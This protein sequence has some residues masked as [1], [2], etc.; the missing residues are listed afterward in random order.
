VWHDDCPNPPGLTTDGCVVQSRVERLTVTGN[1]VTARKVLVQDWCQQFSSHSMG[2][3][4]FGPD[5]A[6][7]VGGGEGANFDN[8]DYGEF[9]GTQAG[10][11]TPYNPCGDPAVPA[12]ARPTPPNAEGGALRAQDARTP[13]DPQTLDGT[14]IRID[15]DTGAALPDNPN[16]GAS[17]A[18]LRRIIG[19]GF[20]N[21]W[22]LSF[23]PGTND[24]YEGDVGWNQYEE[25]NN[26]GD[27][28]SA[29][30][31][32]GWPCYEGSVPQPLF[33]P[34]GLT[35]CNNLYSSGAAT[36]PY[37]AY[38][39]SGAVKT[40]D[41]CGTS[42]GAITAMTFY[43]NGNY[44]AQYH[45]AL[46]FGDYVRNCL[47]VMT[48]GANGKP[49]P[50]TLTRFALTPGTQGHGIV[51]IE[52]GPGGD[53]YYVDMFAG[54]LN[55]IR[56]TAGGNTPPNAVATATPN[57]GPVPLHVAFDGRQ[58]NDPDGDAI[59]YAWDLDGDGAYD[60]STSATPTRDYAQSGAVTVGLKVTDSRGGSDTTTVVVTPGNSPPTITL[61]QPTTATT[62]H[63][64][65]S[66]P[67][68]A[69]ATDLDDGTIPASSFSW[70]VELHHCSLA[71][72]CHLHPWQTINDVRSGSFTAP[73]HGYPAYLTVT[74]T[75]TDS[76][77]ASASKSVDIQPETTTLTLRSLPSGLTLTSSNQSSAS[78]FTETVIVGS[79]NVLTA[80]GQVM[81]GVGYGFDGWSDG[82]AQTH[83]RNV[84]TPT[85]LTASFSPRTLSATDTTVLERSTT[86]SLHVPVT[87]NKPNVE[88][89][90]VHWATA[91]GT[92]TAPGDFTAS[93]G[94]LTFPPGSTSEDAI[95]PIAGDSAAEP[96]QTFTVGLSG[97][98]KASIAD[99][100]ATVT[101]YDDDGG[102][103]VL[104]PGLAT[105][106]EGA[107]GTSVVRIPY[108]LSRPTS[109][110]VTAAWS[111]ADNTAAA[112]S[113]YVTSSGTLRIIAGQTRT[114]VD[115]TVRGDTVD[116][117]DEMLL[118]KLSGLLNAQLGG[119]YGVG[120]GQIVDDD[121]PPGSPQL[122]GAVGSVLEGDSA[123][124]NVSIPITLSAPSTHAV[125]AS[126]T[127]QDNWAATAPSDYTSQSGSVRFDPGET[128]K[129][130]T[131]PVVGDTS[132]ETDETLL[133]SIT[134]VVG[135][136]LGGWG[137]AF[138][139][140]VDD[141]GPPGSPDL[142]PGT[143]SA[144]EGNSGTRTVTVPVTLSAATS[145]TVTA[146]WK[147]ADFGA[148]APN[149]Y[150]AASGTVT[151]APGSTTANVVVTIVGD[152]VD[153][154]N[155]G[156]VLQFTNVANAGL[157]SPTAG[158]VTILDDDP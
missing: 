20:R 120:F 56:Y 100:S 105:V 110:D 70:K 12:G 38:K 60:D 55:R 155:E 91:P 34:I 8:P 85:T 71:G 131:V 48:P 49:D 146:S 137:Y 57:A 36:A 72:L 144:T 116:E 133:V 32:Y 6:L 102:P 125:T 7:Y 74:V 45:G 108:T 118:V 39:Q 17:D 96:T 117:P 58:S 89:V 150:L 2:G 113:D 50:A 140:I 43:G 68:S 59:T 115:V 87:L 112:G 142:V 66:V 82:G 119:F 80:A 128:T 156:F 33:Q 147:T 143:A 11:P 158:S 104:T 19:Y 9:G 154:P 78:P 25:V 127:T 1:V 81:N 18:N 126:W 13:G 94:T 53:L 97:A 29:V 51:N 99:A 42:G 151:I 61:T 24:L 63:V 28:T 98:T 103:P 114:S 88:P 86:Q 153:E 47:W 4:T 124:R 135:A 52:P 152:T 130:V 123:T 90:T 3:M 10:T 95:V 21:P 27:P 84:S 139:A 111:T 30:E 46:F 109:A 132:D 75:V 134:N 64:N 67:F 23:R 138:G 76:D 31:D 145:S 107:G 157:G 93:S 54:A 148:V 101:I 69:T 79:T 73:D 16:A 141:D 129:V 62:W 40:G 26:I 35:M 83:A 44:P 106:K 14:V 41:G 65:E 22:S 15:P 37:F 5:G 122:L 121:G 149:D 92:A 136:S 77:G